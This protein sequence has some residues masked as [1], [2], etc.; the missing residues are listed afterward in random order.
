LDH[1][2]LVHILAFAIRHRFRDSTP[3][4]PRKFLSDDIRSPL[5]AASQNAFSTPTSDS[6]R[7]QPWTL[8]MVGMGGGMW[9]IDAHGG[10]SQI[11]EALPWARLSTDRWQGL[12][13]GT[14]SIEQ[15]IQSRR[16]VIGGPEG[17]SRWIRERLE[18]LLDRCREYPLHAIEDE[19][20]GPKVVPLHR[21]PGGRR[22]A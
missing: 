2:R 7:R 9:T 18:S 11:A 13:A 5:E 14:L 1:E 3:A 16:L 6:D 10:S 12:I 4:L 22:H 15:L 20:D 8:E 19:S 17:T 21:I